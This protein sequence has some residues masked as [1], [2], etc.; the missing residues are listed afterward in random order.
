MNLL[1]PHSAVSQIGEVKDEVEV[2]DA[3]LGTSEVVSDD[4]LG[5]PDNAFL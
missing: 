5:G 4:G 3:A 1:K 2:V